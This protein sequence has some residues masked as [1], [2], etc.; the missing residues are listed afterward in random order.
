VFLGAAVGLFAVVPTVIQATHEIWAQITATS[1]AMFTVLLL[2]LCGLKWNRWPRF[3]KA[4]LVIAAILALG[5]GAVLI[6]G[7]AS[8]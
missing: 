7:N 6:F 4:G 2:L 8:S 1:R 3:R 5:I